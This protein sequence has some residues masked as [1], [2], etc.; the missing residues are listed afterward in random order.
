MAPGN[1]GYPI[2]IGGPTIIGK[3][4]LADARCREDAA[5][6]GETCPSRALGATPH[7]RGSG[8]RAT[9][10]LAPPTTRRLQTGANTDSVRRHTVGTAACSGGALT[11]SGQGIL[12]GQRPQHCCG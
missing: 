6:S 2:K 9:M 4:M 11:L 12:A 3:P 8:A 1:V 10:A 5:L 7:E